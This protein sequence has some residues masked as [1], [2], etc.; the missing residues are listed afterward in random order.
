MDE[1]STRVEKPGAAWKCWA[2]NM[3]SLQTLNESLWT[4]W[5][6]DPSVPWIVGAASIH[7]RSGS[8]QVRVYQRHGRVL[9]GP[10][11]VNLVR[12]LDTGWLMPSLAMAL[13]QRHSKKILVKPQRSH[14][15]GEWKES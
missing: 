13:G 12:A 7:C 4:R 15:L 8:I 9:R 14:H 5:S 10:R 6:P 11:K 1:P 2:E 3:E